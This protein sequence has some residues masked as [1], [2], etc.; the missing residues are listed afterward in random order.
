MIFSYRDKWYS[1]RTERPIETEFN[2]L[3]YYMAIKIDVPQWVRFTRQIAAIAD[4]RSTRPQIQRIL[5]MGM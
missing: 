1:S 3:E 4:I 2:T 5:Y